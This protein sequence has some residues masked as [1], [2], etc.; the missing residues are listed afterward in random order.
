[1]MITTKQYCNSS[2]EATRIKESPQISRNY[3]LGTEAF[4]IE[5]IL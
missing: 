2:N 4:Y 3:Q 1:M 5:I